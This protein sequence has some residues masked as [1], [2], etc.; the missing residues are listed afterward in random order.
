MFIHVSKRD[1]C[2]FASYIDLDE[3]EKLI[4]QAEDFRILN[5]ICT[6]SALVNHVKYRISILFQIKDQV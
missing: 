6:K 3:L 2:F 4:E 1:N 5:G